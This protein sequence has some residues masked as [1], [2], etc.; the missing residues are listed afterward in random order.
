MGNPDTSS[1]D[2]KYILTVFV[3]SRIYVN[4]FYFSSYLCERR[5]LSRSVLLAN[6]DL[7]TYCLSLLFDA[8]YLRNVIVHF[9]FFNLFVFGVGKP[10]N[11]TIDQVRNKWSTDRSKTGG[12]W[13][14]G[15]RF[16]LTIK[17]PTSN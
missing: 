5:P 4:T 10:E 11:V 13:T 8:V 2:S 17:L 12:P 16:V 15:P 6:L 1:P 9:S 3:F 14:P 7:V